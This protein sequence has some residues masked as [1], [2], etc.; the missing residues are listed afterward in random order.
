[1]KTIETV[2]ASDTTIDL[3]DLS[4]VTG[5]A[6]TNCTNCIEQRPFPFPG[7]EHPFPRPSPVPFPKPKP[8]PGPFPGPRNPLEILGGGS[9][10]GG[11]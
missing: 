9:A 10:V 8:F 5:G 2:T 4:R 3:A 7:G 1:M 6:A 11:V